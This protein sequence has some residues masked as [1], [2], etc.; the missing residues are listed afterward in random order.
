MDIRNVPLSVYGSYMALAYYK[1]DKCNF[2]GVKDEALYLKSLRGK[3]RSTPAVCK[4]L[5]LIDGQEA[6]FTYEA[7]LFHIEIYFAG[8]CIK[9]CFDGD[10]RII[11]KVEGEKSGL[12]LDFMP[13]S[14]YE[15][16]FTLGTKDKPYHIINSYKTLTKYIVK[17]VNGQA[18]LNQEN[19]K[20]LLG[21][22][23]SYI[24]VNS[25]NND[26][27]ICVI[28]EIPTHMI[29]PTEKE[30]SYEASLEETTKKFEAFYEAFPKVLPEYEEAYKNA[31][32]V[33]WSCTVK[34]F[35]SLKRDG[36]YM[37]NNLFQGIWS[38]DHCFNALALANVHNELAWD[39]MM[40]LFDH[41]DE[42]GQIPGS[43]SDSTVRWNFAK[44]PIHGLFIEK[45]MKKTELSKEQLLEAFDCIEKQVNFWL[46]FK[47]FDQ[48]GICEYHHGNDSGYDN[49]TVF[50]DDFVA[51]SPD[52]SAFLIKAM[53]TLAIIAEKLGRDMEER[54]WYERS[55]DL[56]KLT[57]ERFVREEKIIT[58]SGLEKN[59]VESQ[60][61]LPY[62]LVILGDRLPKDLKNKIVNDLKNKFMTEY[63]LATEAT[64][65]PYYNPDGYWR[66]PIWG[67]T[68]VLF[69]EGLEECGEVEFA[70]ELTE[71]FCKLVKKSG[72]AENFNAITGDPLC[73]K[74]Y[75]WT[76][77]SFIHLCEKMNKY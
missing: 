6:D 17:S 8:G 75:T 42:N 73:D 22:I 45:M 52:L 34:K 1:D 19:S 64:D 4:I 16:N 40:V 77:S 20:S 55:D 41:Q 48:D 74:A 33:D 30:Y 44:P 29:K 56:T 66:G 50:M 58:Y 54:L 11:F 7:D 69:I 21:S 65:S 3:S 49:S 18:I 51:E 10:S 31:V 70:K 57:L 38:W 2:R 68:M 67:P 9:I 37:S 60:S 36:M 23:N 47:D 62:T 43:V 27:F 72:C 32:Y 71:K 5:P 12:R 26:S 25:L 63:G 53:E 24:D 61:I 28:E 59:I 39:Q 15:Y 14:E 76:A 35:G 13:S 46:N